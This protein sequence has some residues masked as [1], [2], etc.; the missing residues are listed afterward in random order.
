MNKLVLVFGTVGVLTCGFTVGDSVHTVIENVKQVQVDLSK[1]KPLGWYLPEKVTLRI[2]NCPES[3]LDREIG[4]TKDS[5][6][7]FLKDRLKDFGFAQIS[8]SG[9]DS[10]SLSFWYSHPGFLG[11]KEF[12]AEQ[13]PD[14]NTVYLIKTKSG[15]GMG[16]AIGINARIRRNKIMI[17]SI[18]YA[19]AC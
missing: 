19:G 11:Q 13:R 7:Q 2:T 1:A 14:L 15:F 10:V 12:D 9:K 18:H 17:S 6:I 16:D 8:F 4:I 3:E 5:A